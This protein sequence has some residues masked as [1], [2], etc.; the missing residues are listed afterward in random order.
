MI[1]CHS[2]LEVDPA[3]AMGDLRRLALFSL[4][5]LVT[6]L[7]AS[8]TSSCVSGVVCAVDC[9]A[10][11]PRVFSGQNRTAGGEGGG[12]GTTCGTCTVRDCPPSF[13]NFPNADGTHFLADGTKVWQDRDYKWFGVGTDVEQAHLVTAP[14]KVGYPFNTDWDGDCCSNTSSGDYTDCPARSVGMVAE[15]Q[16]MP[17]SCPGGS[18]IDGVVFAR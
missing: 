16:T 12:C 7:S 15:H 6:K 8:C 5:C 14:F 11:F 3:R 2:L 13:T 17:L 10:D 9:P 4:A 1:R 18:T